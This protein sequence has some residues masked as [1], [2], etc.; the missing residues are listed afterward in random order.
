MTKKKNVS[1]K[2]VRA[3]DLSISDMNI[4]ENP[5]TLYKACHIAF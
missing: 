4:Y 5:L 3:S 2:A 1:D